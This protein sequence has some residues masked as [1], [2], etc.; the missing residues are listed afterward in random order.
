MALHA[1]SSGCS[2]AVFVQASR[3]L[4]EARA[5][6]ARHARHVSLMNSSAAIR[7]HRGVWF[8]TKR[9]LSEISL[10]AFRETRMKRVLLVGCAV[11]SLF[12]APSMASA[13]PIDLGLFEVAFDVD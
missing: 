6:V 10:V 2:C 12:V 8:A 4:H 11:M 1:S 9:H 13:A 7:R 3:R 5:D